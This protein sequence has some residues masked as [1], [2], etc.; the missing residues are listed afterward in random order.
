MLEN[1]SI[2]NNVQLNEAGFFGVW[3]KQRL[4]SVRSAITA[5][6]ELLV[7]SRLYGVRQSLANAMIPILTIKWQLYNSKQ[8]KYTKS[9]KRKPTGPR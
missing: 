4:H 2:Y 7:T 1:T 5:T 9:T 6:A 8:T 3:A